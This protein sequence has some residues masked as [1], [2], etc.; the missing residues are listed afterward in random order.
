MPRGV[1][2]VWVTSTVTPTESSPGPRNGR[3]TR[4]AAISISATMREVERTGGYESPPSRLRA[5]ARS[6]RETKNSAEAVALISGSL[7]RGILAKRRRVTGVL[8]KRRSRRGLHPFD[9]DHPRARR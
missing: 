6:V 8:L 4:E 9:D 5:L 3:K 1:A 7:I 2:A